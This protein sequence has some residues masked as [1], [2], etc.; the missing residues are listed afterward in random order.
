MKP[1]LFTHALLAPKYT[2]TPYQSIG[3]QYDFSSKRFGHS[4]EI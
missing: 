2:K 3:G 1:V 4:G